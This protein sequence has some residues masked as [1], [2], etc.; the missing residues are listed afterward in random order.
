MQVVEAGPYW[1]WCRA[2][3]EPVRVDTRLVGT[4]T[5]GAWLLV[6]QGAAR[7]VM[8]ED[9]ALLVRDALTA[10]DRAAAGEPFDHLFPDLAGREPQLPEFL[11]QRV[12][13]QG[14]PSEHHAP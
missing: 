6:F 1:A 12:D 10:L 8:D 9:Q 5:A 11:R 4:Q 7:E 14:S 13:E 3:G 2:G